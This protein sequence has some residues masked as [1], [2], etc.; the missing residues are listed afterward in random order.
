MVYARPISNL[1]ERHTEA[2]IVQVHTPPTVLGE[3]AATTDLGPCA[4][5]S[6]ESKSTLWTNAGEI[7]VDR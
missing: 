3:A 2:A 4:E 5:A 1:A 7:I 6:P